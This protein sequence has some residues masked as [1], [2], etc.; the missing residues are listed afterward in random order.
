MIPIT[1]FT[2]HPHLHIDELNTLL[3]IIIKK[4]DTADAGVSQFTL[5]QRLL[6]SD[7]EWTALTSEPRI[8]RRLSY[9]RQPPQQ[10][11]TPTELNTIKAHNDQ[12]AYIQRTFNHFETSLVE[13][14][15]KD[16]LTDIDPDG[17]GLSLTKSPGDIMIGLNIRFGQLSEEQVDLL[18]A[19]LAIWDNQKDFFA[20][21]ANFKQTITLLQKHMLMTSDEDIKIA[22]QNLLSNGPYPCTEMML[23]FR[24]KNPK[25]TDFTLKD[26]YSYVATNQSI[27]PR[28]NGNGNGNNHSHSHAN[29]AETNTDSH[30]AEAA[31][32]ASNSSITGKRKNNHIRPNSQIEKPIGWKNPHTPMF[33]FAHGYCNH[34]SYKCRKLHDEPNTSNKMLMSTSPDKHI[35]GKDGI[36]Y[37]PNTATPSSKYKKQPKH[38]SD[39]N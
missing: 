7:A 16:T 19:K 32:A 14:L 30:D 18:L 9:D 5:S 8:P 17:A 37:A 21:T 10:P 20:N 22:F 39:E 38:E 31:A 13:V 25:R 2:K 29:L 28:R 4:L 23:A 34:W 27:Y 26:I 24:Q 11:L 3:P 35:H 6:L 36:L 33:C 1:D 12:S 15:G